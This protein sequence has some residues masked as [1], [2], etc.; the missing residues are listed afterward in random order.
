M[1]Q[2]LLAILLFLSLT[3]SLFA[4]EVPSSGE[5]MFDIIAIRP[6]GAASLG[7]GLVLFT[8]SSP[9]WLLTPS[10]LESFRQTGR[11]LVVYPFSFTFQRPIGDFPGYTEEL[12]FVAE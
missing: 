3:G 4:K 11:R 8:V 12:E 7:V 10:P 9:F 6:L 5:M 1:K 2:K